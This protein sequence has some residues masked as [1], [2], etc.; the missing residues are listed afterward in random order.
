M[1]GGEEGFVSMGGKGEGAKDAAEFCFR[2]EGVIYF[3][4]GSE[5]IG[6]AIGG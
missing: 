2:V 5:G 1:S 4:E 3:G 6:G